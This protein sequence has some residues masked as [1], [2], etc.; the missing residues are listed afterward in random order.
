MIFWSMPGGEEDGGH[1]VI[2]RPHNAGNRFV[3]EYLGDSP[4]A[5]FSRDNLIVLCGDG[6]HGDRLCEP[7]RL[8]AGGEFLESCLMK[9]G[10]VVL[11]RHD[12]ADR[13]VLNGGVSRCH[14][15]RSPY[16]S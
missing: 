2:H 16:R 15:W 5:T 1:L 6:T 12:L 14:D 8:N 4:E 10:A 9:I 11:A 13:N 3:L 7:V